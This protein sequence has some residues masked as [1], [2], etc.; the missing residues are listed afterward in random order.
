ML[1]LED[2]AQGLAGGAVKWLVKQIAGGILAGLAGHIAGDVYEWLKGAFACISKGPQ[3]C[4]DFYTIVEVVKE[5]L[6]L[7]GFGLHLKLF[8]YL[9]SLFE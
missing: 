3:G 1:R 8:E 2:W 4:K 9:V 7:K 6:R 5:V